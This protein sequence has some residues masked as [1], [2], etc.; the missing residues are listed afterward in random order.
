MTTLTKIFSDVL[1][2]LAFMFRDDEQGEWP[3][4]GLWLE[5][6][7]S[8]DGTASGTLRLRCTRQ[9]SLVLAANLLGTD[10]QEDIA[11][12][13]ADDAVKEFMNV[14]CGQFV[15]AVHGTQE[16][17]HLTI[18]EI[19]VMNDPPPPDDDEYESSILAVEGEVLLLTYVPRGQS[20]AVGSGSSSQE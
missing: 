2:D 5:T 12:S 13:A 20:A 19:I 18:P 4:G 15:T 8:Y 9:F 3:D 6:T 16:V 11:E 14:V 7:I 17:F 1:S 10:P